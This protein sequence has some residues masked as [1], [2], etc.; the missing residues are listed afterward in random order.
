M[1][2]G[3]PWLRSFLLTVVAFV[4]CISAAS[5][6]T[7][8][9]E[10]SLASEKLHISGIRDA[11]KVNDFLYRGAQPNDKVLEELQELGITTIVDL[12]GERHGLITKERKHAESL[13]MD[14]INLPGNGWSPPPDKQVAQFFSL[15]QETPRRR[16]FL[17]CWLGG[18]RSGVFIATYRIAFDGWTPEQAIREM[19]VFHYNSF[20]HPAM[21]KY[22]REFPSR[23]ESSPELASFRH[24][25][26][27]EKN[28]TDEESR[29]SGNL[30]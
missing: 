10:Q 8:P 21:T 17:H 7:A 25:E 12:R 23:L 20:W 16:V 18:D 6:A 19:H 15:M 2:Y 14:F 30:Q 9:V 1:S 28:G 11:G 3:G 4:G 13:G 26:S 27:G 22:V 24:A 29:T 5:D